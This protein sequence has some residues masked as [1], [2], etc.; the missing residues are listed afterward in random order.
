M[1]N[2]AN[3]TNKLF[4]RAALYA[5]VSSEQQTQTQTIDS[6]VIAI[7]ER[8]QN[9]GLVL[10]KECCFIDDGYSGATLIRPALERLRDMASMGTFDRVYILCPDRLSRNYA[11]Q[12]LLIDELQRCGVDVTFLNYDVGQTPEDQLLL[13]AQGMIAEYERAK[14]M[15]RSRRGKLYAARQGSVGPIGK[16]P[17]GYHYVT[18]HESG[19]QA[20]YQ[21]DLDKSRVVRKIF[22][23]IGQDH[24]ALQEV[25]RRL[26]QQGIKTSKGHNTWSRT[27]IW[28]IANN[29]AYMG[30]AA[31][32]RTCIGP[33]RPRLRALRN[34]PEQPRRAVSVYRVPD[35]KWITIPV[36]A[37]VSV[38]L[39]N[40]VQEQMEQNRK[41]AR[42]GQRGA[43]F[44]LQGLVV[45]S[46]CGYAFY[47][48]TM[49]RHTKKGKSYSYSYYRCI[50]SDSY[51][52]EG[53]HKCRNKQIRLE[54][55]DDAVWQDVCCLLREPDR[56][57]REYD[58]RLTDTHVTEEAEQLKSLSAKIKRGIERLIDAYQESLID[59]AEFSPRL[60]S[61][62]D[63]L[64]LI[65]EQLQN[66]SQAANR[67]MHL[68]CVI[69]QVETFAD[70]VKDS[71]GK[72]DFASKRQ[73]IRALVKQIEIGEEE[74][75]LVYR[76]DNLPFAQT[77]E[78][79]FVQ[80]CS[81]RVCS[82][83]RLIIN[84]NE[85]AQRILILYFVHFA[86]FV[87]Q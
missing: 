27:S 63:R 55:L 4:V 73:I 87:V 62:K 8:I 86:S 37:I 65:D 74:V 14:I 5:R 46:S 42:E 79:G 7:K 82:H 51:R 67:T 53:H 80:H 21:I 50:G 85:Y 81:K 64:R 56:I 17:Y 20:S 66:A 48:R 29:P 35:D 58:R 47:G 25:A 71:L 3:N 54:Q 30:K 69:G 28:Q 31:Y 6:Q 59:Y 1:G 77:P 19:C 24:I 76:V 36:P 9:D 60:Q 44:L 43:R 61:S 26:Q 39:F 72:A 38:D 75:K 34:A 15:E 18:R 32:G 11:Y 12:V 2:V 45:C 22:Q 23:W 41:R 84:Q 40:T 16:A 83:L 10:G 70:M 57:R 49:T 52:Y 68:K 78:K 33:R 13:Q